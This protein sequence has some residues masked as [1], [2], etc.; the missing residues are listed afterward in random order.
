[1]RPNMELVHKLVKEKNWTASHLARR[2]G[3]S[4]MEA[5]RLLHGTRVGGKKCI[6]GLIKAFPDIPLDKLFFLK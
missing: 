5:S 3:I 6:G 1:M 2:M 4:K